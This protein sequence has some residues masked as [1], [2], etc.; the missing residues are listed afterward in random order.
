L[1][2]VGLEVT[3]RHTYKPFADTRQRTPAHSTFKAKPISATPTQS[4][5][6]I[7]GQPAGFQTEGGHGRLLVEI[8]HTGDMPLEP[9]DTYRK[10]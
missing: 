4:M 9:I 1:A 2:G 7:I 5:L 10:R 8:T 6:A 3:R